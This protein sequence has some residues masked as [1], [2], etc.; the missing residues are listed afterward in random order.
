MTAASPGVVSFV[1]ASLLVLESFAPSLA[2]LATALIGLIA[3][4]LSVLDW[5]SRGRDGH[6]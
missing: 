4:S 3:A 2:M 5:Y 1:A 6:D